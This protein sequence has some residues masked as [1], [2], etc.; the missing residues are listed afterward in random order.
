[1]LPFIQT[2]IVT[3]S[4][5]LLSEQVLFCKLT[6]DQRQVYQNFLDSKEVYQILNG[7]MQVI[8]LCVKPMCVFCFSFKE[9]LEFA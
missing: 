8:D 5:V 7:D 3:A 2:S 6:E 1:M 4:N 9:L